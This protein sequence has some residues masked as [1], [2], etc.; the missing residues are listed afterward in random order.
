MKTKSFTAILLGAFI[1]LWSVEIVNAQTI[2]PHRT[3]FAVPKAGISHYAGDVNHGGSPVSWI[4]GLEVGYQATSR[5]NASGTYL[6]GQYPQIAPGYDRRHTA[7]L[8][9]RWTG[10]AASAPVAP[11]AQVGLHGTVGNTIWNGARSEDQF[12]M[13]PVL[14][15]GVDFVL[16]PM[17]SLYLEG[18][19]NISKPNQALDGSDGT[20]FMGGRFD[21]LNHVMGGIRFNM[22][23]A[24]ELR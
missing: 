5:F 12:A 20:N 1:L 9:L 11:F 18:N 24:T 6:V 4:S 21:M 16:T 15:I 14:G 7:Q 23:S 17:I 10:M 22:R 13:G 3:F 2:R 8:L 19:T